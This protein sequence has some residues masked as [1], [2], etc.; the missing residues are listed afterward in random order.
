MEQSKIRALIVDDEFHA[1]ENLKFL[2]EENSP[3]IEVIGTADGVPSAIQ[4]FHELKP[5]LLFLDIRMPSGAEGFDLLEELK[6]EKFQVIFVT[7]FKDYAIRAFER[8][9]L[10]YILKPIDEEDLRESVERILDS[11]NFDSSPLE[12]DKF[13]NLKEEVETNAEPERITVNHSK[14]IRIVEL[15]EL[16]Y[17]QSSGNCTVLHFKTGEQY[18]D[19]RTMKIYEAILPNYFQRVHRSYIVN[20]KEATEIL[21]G[22][23]QEIV[24]KSKKHVPISR[25]RKKDLTIAIQNIL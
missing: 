2:I 15:A 23:H 19:T 18:L 4:R 16:E 12:Y 5:E 22:D 1:R 25:E 14:G 20:L 7:A 17:L 13:S 11:R 8:R 3:E 21:H 10:H 9:A 24:L 6:G